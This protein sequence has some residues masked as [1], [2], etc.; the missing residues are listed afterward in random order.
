MPFKQRNL[1]LWLRQQIFKKIPP[2]NKNKQKQPTNIQNKTKQTNNDV[3]TD[4]ITL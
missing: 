2:P 3:I 4:K 1:N